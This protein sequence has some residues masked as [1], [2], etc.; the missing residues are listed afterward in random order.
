MELVFWGVRGSCPVSGPRQQF[1]GGETSCVAVHVEGQPP[2]LCD[3]GTGLRN[4]FETVDLSGPPVEANVLL[5]HLHWD[6]VLGL[7]FAAP[8]SLTEAKVDIYAPPQ[9]SGGLVEVFGRFMQPPFFPVDVTQL[10]AKV[11]FHEVWDQDVELGAI[12]VLVRPVP[13]VGAT[14]GFRIEAEGVSVAYVSDHQEP[15]SGEIAQ[16]V[17][18]LCDG[19]DLVIHDAQYDEQELSQRP[20]WGH[21]SVAYAVR[22]ALESG[23]RSLMLFHHDPGHDDATVSRMLSDAR[24]LPGAKR[25]ALLEAARERSRLVLSPGRTAYFAPNPS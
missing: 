2:L 25:L 1:Y 6:H 10:K 3:L 16:S 22:V 24:E 12:R 18:E 21:S 8:L 4:A 9:E 14:S 20:D 7:P 13:H 23:A 15:P 11:D 5:S 19:A 17:L